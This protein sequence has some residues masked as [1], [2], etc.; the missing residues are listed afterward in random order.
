VGQGR[1]GQASSKAPMCMRPRATS[2]SVQL[3]KIM[4]S[5]RPSHVVKGEVFM[6][7]T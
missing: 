3:Y 6:L 7:E 5:V 4:Y 2:C 1:T